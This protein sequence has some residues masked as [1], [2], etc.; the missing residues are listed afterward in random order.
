MMTI[1]KKRY[2][3]AYGSTC[4]VLCLYVA[5]FLRIG[6][7][8]GAGDAV[9]LVIFCKC[10]LTQEMLVQLVNFGK[11]HSPLRLW[12]SPTGTLSM[13]RKYWNV[14]RPSWNLGRPSRL[15]F[16]WCSWQWNMCWG[17]VECVLVHAQSTILN[18]YIVC[19]WSVF[20]VADPRQKFLVVVGC[21]VPS[22]PCRNNLCKP[23]REFIKSCG[24]SSIELWPNWLLY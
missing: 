20:T 16:R 15:F 13:M 5:F 2:V 11:C 4:D 3:Q 19:P 18:W 9:K 14:G 6:L 24:P 10:I 1:I 23:A 22:W 7:M 21:S 12:L 8:C 17:D